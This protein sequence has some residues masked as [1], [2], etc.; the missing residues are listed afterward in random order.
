MDKYTLFVRRFLAIR[1]WLRSDEEVPLMKIAEIAP[2]AESCPPKLYGGT[3]RVVSYLTE[4]LVAQGHEVTLFASGQTAAAQR[5]APAI[6][7]PFPSYSPRACRW[8]A[9]LC[10]QP[11]KVRSAPAGANGIRFSSNG[12]RLKARSAHPRSI[13]SGSLQGCRSCILES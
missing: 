7:M 11:P 6:S 2:L 8:P 4:E 5:S 9:L 13:Q 12:P 1:R 10:H 3:E